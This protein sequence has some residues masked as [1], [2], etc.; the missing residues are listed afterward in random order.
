M[1][2]STQAK[3]A[4]ELCEME[5][6]RLKFTTESDVQYFGTVEKLQRKVLEILKAKA[7]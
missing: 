6:S 4:T 2:C 1:I 3:C 5:R 7:R